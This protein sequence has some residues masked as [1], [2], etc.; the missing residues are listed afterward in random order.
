[1]AESLRVETEPNIATEEVAAGFANSDDPDN[2]FHW[3]S[4]TKWTV[5]LT[6]CFVCFIV[7]L[8][9]TGIAS[10]PTPI[11][12][13]FNISDA[14]FPN[15]FWP[16]ASWTIGAA[17]VPMIVLP[18]MEKYG[19][20]SGYLWSYGT[21]FVF[22]IPQAVAPNFATL[23]VC[24]FIAGSA[25][26][27]LQN[28]MDG[29]IADIWDGPVQRS[30]PI[31]IYVTCL[32]AG[33]SLG[34]V[35]GGVVVHNLYWRWIFYIQ[36]VIYGVTFIIVLLTMKETRAP[37]ITSKRS[38]AEGIQKAPPSME[39]KNSPPL[40]P[41]KFFY[42]TLILPARLLCTE[43]VV[44]FF[45]LLSALS[46]GIAFIS[47][48]SVTQVFVTNFGFAEYQA[49]L[50]QASIVIGEILGFVGCLF[51]NA[52]Y[53]RTGLANPHK[54]EA[55]VSEVRLYLS[56]PASFIGLAGGLLWYGWTSYQ[57]LPWILPAIGLAMTSFGVTVVMQAIMM[58]ITDAYARYA[59]SA[60]AAVCFG[61]NIFAAFLPLAAQSMYANLG[62][63]WASSL[64]GF[65]ALLLSFA[66]ILLVWKGKDIRARS[67]FI[68][69]ASTS[70][71]PFLLG[72]H[73]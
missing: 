62:F 25:A 71:N 19:T 49:G 70:Y 42:D 37:V 55:D 47:T 26:G 48:Q 8:N 44:F 3:P 61:E 34:P 36:L 4:R 52:L 7:G 2:P 6:T 17:I 72:R 11:N 18:L 69:E 64:L 21:F 56:I 24:R 31:T 33:V 58:Y 27:V 32:L 39:A 16:V 57:S 63:Q 68:K 41:A 38:R 40:S 30:L 73:C 12:D 23:V 35:Y 43:P 60:S 28:G 22:V 15:S 50:V 14:N 65:I 20:R 53:K 29:I 1:M 5:T 13:R 66:P 59:A 54:S 10:A 45:T 67:P 51:Q 9:A 46:Y